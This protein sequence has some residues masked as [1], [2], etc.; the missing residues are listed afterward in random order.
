MPANE[1]IKQLERQVK[2]RRKHL[3][4]LE[5]ELESQKKFLARDEMKAL[6]GKCFV[7]RET[8]HDRAPYS[9]Y[10]KVLKVEFNG[11]SK[12]NHILYCIE[13]QRYDNYYKGKR[14][15]V[16]TT[17]RYYQHIIDKEEI[18][19]ETFKNVLASYGNWIIDLAE[20]KVK[21]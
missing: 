12:N 15:E 5:R 4:S 19:Q 21:A 16:D 10:W 14:L 1:Y 20:G 9:I 18:S 7:S 2:G 13:V 3:I 8:N 17:T 11:S 6:V